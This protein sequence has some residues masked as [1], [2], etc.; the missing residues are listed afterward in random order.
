MLPL[1]P[2][3]AQEFAANELAIGAVF[4]LYS[5]CQLITAPLIGAFSDRWGRKPLLIASQAGTTLGF[6]IL[7]GANTL[8]LIFL[9]RAVDG[10]SAGNV[11]LVYSAVLNHYSREQ[12]TRAFAWLGTASGLGIVAG[13]L[14]GALLSA[15][16]WALPAFVAAGLSGLTILLTLVAFP[17]QERADGPPL[18]N[19]LAL[20]GRRDIRGM[21]SMILLNGVIFNAFLL[22]MPL[23]LE[24]QLGYTA[25]NVGLLVTGLFLLAAVFQVTVLQRLLA[26]QTNRTSARIGFGLYSAGFAVLIFAADLPLVVVAGTLVIGAWRS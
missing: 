11:A 10:L 20:F 19:A 25:Q 17:A 18:R 26:T 13:P 5:L 1:I 3:I 7:G 6:L 14:I 23:F 9:S 2:F 21:L 24:R 16:G 4:A 8:P 12:R 22:A 15:R